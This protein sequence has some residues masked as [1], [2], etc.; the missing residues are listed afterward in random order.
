MPVSGLSGHRGLQH[1]RVLQLV[2]EADLSIG[3][4]AGGDF[5]FDYLTRTHSRA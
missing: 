2:G 5:R 1:P 4:G 3:V